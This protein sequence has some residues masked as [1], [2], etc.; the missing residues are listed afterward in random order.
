[1]YCKIC[2]IYLELA[3]NQIIPEYIDKVCGFH[4]IQAGEL[5]ECLCCKSLV[6]Y[7]DV[8]LCNWCRNPICS[9]C[10]YNGTH[11]D[12]YDCYFDPIES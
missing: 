8:V 4:N 9:I 5:Q 3:P 10:C 6:K 2:G 11:N 12:K 1:M 7:N